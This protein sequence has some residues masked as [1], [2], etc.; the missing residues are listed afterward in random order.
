MAFKESA[1]GSG[2]HSGMKLMSMETVNR[3]KSVVLLLNVRRSS[4]K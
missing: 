1:T 2:Q 4:M 3:L